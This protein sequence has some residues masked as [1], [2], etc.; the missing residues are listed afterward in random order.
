MRYELYLTKLK[1]GC[2]LNWDYSD[3]TVLTTLTY[4]SRDPGTRGKIFSVASADGN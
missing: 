1:K 2:D 3:K 4:P